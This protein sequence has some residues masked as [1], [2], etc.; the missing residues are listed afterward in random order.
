MSSI[1]WMM[2]AYSVVGDVSSCTAWEYD[3]VEL[4]VWKIG[5][6]W[7]QRC[8][9]DGVGYSVYSFVRY[10]FVLIYEIGVCFH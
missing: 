8:P 1:A 4:Y 10:S 9:Q 2:I 7:T 6:P 5:N 3:L